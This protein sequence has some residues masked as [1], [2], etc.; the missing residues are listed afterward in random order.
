MRA[1]L[2]A[3]LNE[4]VAGGYLA[5]GVPVALVEKRTGVKAG[6]AVRTGRIWRAG[7]SMP[8]SADEDAVLRQSL[9]CMS[10]REIAARLGRS[11]T[12]VHL[13]WKRDL[14]LPAPSKTPGTLTGRRAADLLG[15]GMHL[16]SYFVDRGMVPGRLMPG[17]RKIR[18]IEYADLLRWSV[19]PEHWIYFKP[20]RVRDAHIRRMIDLRRDRW[21]D[22]WW[23]TRRAADY[24]GVQVV[25]YDGRRNVND[26]PAW[27]YWF[28]CRSEVM[29]AKFYRG[30]GSAMAMANGQRKGA[31]PAEARAFMLLARG[32]GLPYKAIAGMM[33]LK[34]KRVEYTVCTIEQRSGGIPFV[35]WRDVSSRL[36]CIGRAAAS[37][38][39]GRPL[40]TDQVSILRS[41]MLAW[42]DRYGVA[43]PGTRM[44]YMTIKVLKEM[45]ARLD[46][47]GVYP[48]GRE[49]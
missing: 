39:A 19:N 21:G 16:M 6:H 48:F 40:S 3:M 33:H 9:G 5:A 8:W 11:I 15:V 35:D 46:C 20:E 49:A 25:N 34:T 2:D 7:G 1:E 42:G 47:A 23:T 31:L 24:H 26:L 14:R 36:P 13:R 27:S 38:I 22:E 43:L 28:V 17:D 37:F 29:A 18:L 10:E 44:P 41:V 45:N 32:A 30:K 12:A 4:A